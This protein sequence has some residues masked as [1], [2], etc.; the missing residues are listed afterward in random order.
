MAPDYKARLANSLS[1][2]PEM[3]NLKL[4]IVLQHVGVRPL[5]LLEDD[6][7][8]LSAAAKVWYLSSSRLSTW[9]LFYFTLKVVRR[10]IRDKEG[11]ES[12][13]YPNYR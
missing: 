13:Y 6:Q 3:L 8:V 5:F 11:K 7:H 2:Y 12:H 1:I 4:R 10:G 9:P